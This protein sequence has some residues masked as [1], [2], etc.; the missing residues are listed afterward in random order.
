MIIVITCVTHS[1]VN[2]AGFVTLKS[3]VRINNNFIANNVEHRT[4]PEYLKTGTIYGVCLISCVFKNNKKTMLVS[5][6]ISQKIS[7]DCII[8]VITKIII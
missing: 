3:K 4:N 2:I 6:I 8:E 7:Y 1:A 5:I